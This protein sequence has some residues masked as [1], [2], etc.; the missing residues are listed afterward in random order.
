MKTSNFVPIIRYLFLFTSYCLYVY[1]RKL[2]FLLSSDIKNEIHYT[3]EQY[4]SIISIYSF[5]YTLS[6]LLI[7]ALND[8]FHPKNVLTGGLFVIC[9]S[10]LAM[11]Q[12]ESIS[13]FYLW[14]ALNSF[15][16]GGGWA[17]L[18]KLLKIVRFL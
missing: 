5:C 15:C 10:I 8:I 3:T 16:Q 13:E 11:S 9:I 4:G 7:G 18:I 14:I 6:K 12:V 2:F 17:A 1:Y